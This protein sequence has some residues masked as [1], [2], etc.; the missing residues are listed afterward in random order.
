MQTRILVTVAVLVLSA[1]PLSAQSAS[2]LLEK[3]I[4]L[5][6]TAGQV[7]QAIEI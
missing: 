1:V 3:G 2:E 5:E 4:Y 7:D 6:E